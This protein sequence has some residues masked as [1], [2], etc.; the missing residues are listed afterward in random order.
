[1]KR[2]VSKRFELSDLEA[3]MLKMKADQCGLG[4]ADYIRELIMNSQPVEAPPRQ[5]YE[6]MEKVNRIASRIQRICATAGDKDGI[7]EL[8]SLYV[9]LIGHIVEI[10]EC[11]SKARFYALGAYQDW[12]HQVE[13]AKKEGRTPPTLR[14]YIPPDHSRD[15][16]EP[17]TDPELGW[18]A[19]GIRPPF[20]TGEEVESFDSTGNNNDA[21]KT[22]LQGVDAGWQNVDDHQK[23]QSIESY[24]ES[25]IYSPPRKEGDP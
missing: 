6:Q 19:L 14:E 18:N 16:E 8:K 24:A 17:A 9:E 22:G 11:V 15:I 23:E 20:L 10:K 21:G 2:E 7:A 3:K 25:R 13:M 1:M 4:E 12:E 5:F